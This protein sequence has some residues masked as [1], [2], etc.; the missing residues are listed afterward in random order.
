M[1][2]QA[3]RTTVA[4]AIVLV[5]AIVVAQFRDAETVRFVVGAG[6]VIAALSWLFFP[7]D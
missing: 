6:I 1:R 5:I 7:G 4:I 2:S 3:K